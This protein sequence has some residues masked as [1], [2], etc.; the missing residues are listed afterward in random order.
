LEICIPLLLDRL[1]DELP[2]RPAVVQ[3]EG[4]GPR[5][6][7]RRQFGDRARALAAGLRARGFGCHTERDRL[8]PHE[9][10]Q[11]HLAVCLYNSAPYLEAMVGAMYAR[12]AP[13]NVNYRYTGDELVQVL[14]T[15]RARVLVYDARL[16]G[17]VLPAARQVPG[18]DLLLEVTQPGSAASDG[19]ID[20]EQFLRDAPDEPDA[21]RTGDGAAHDGP[22]ADDL[23]LV[24]TGGTTGSPKAVLWRQADLAVAALGGRNFAQ[25]G[26]EWDALDEMAAAAHGR[27]AACLSAAPFMHGAGQWMALQALGTGGTVVLPHD[28]TRFDPLDVLTTCRDGHVQALLLVGDTMARP[29]AEAVTAHGIELP[30]LRLIASGGAPLSPQGRAALAAALPGARIRDTM[31]SSE[32]GPQAFATTAGDEPGVFDPGPG[33]CVVDEPR[34][35]TLAPGEDEVGWL[36]SAGRVPLGYLGDAERTAATFPVI[37]GR[38]FSVSGDRARFRADGRIAVL[39]RASSVINTGGEKVFAEEVE[40][41]VREFAGVTDVVVVPRPSERWGQEVAALVAVAGPLDDRAL[42]AHCRER[43]AGYKVPKVVVPV[44]AIPRN[45]AGKVDMRWAA[46]AAVNAS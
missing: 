15:A 1:E 42:L 4:T 26:C 22:S 3:F 28:P 31:G 17:V 41:V 8:A 30:A 27:P 13:A 38:R 32:S 23:V 14:R 20:Y 10:G 16:A 29:L 5:T 33:T 18:L 35:R 11:D 7:S 43:L 44:P 45:P 40:A 12:L 24:L 9:S 6:L 36:A 37:D 46:D 19:A 25:K 2:D 39:G 34:T 21:R